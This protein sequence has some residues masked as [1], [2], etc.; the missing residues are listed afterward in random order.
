MGFWVADD[1]AD[2]HEHEAIEHLEDRLHDKFPAVPNARIDD[3]VEAHYHELD[4]QPVREYVPILV[5]HAAINEL[6][7]HAQTQ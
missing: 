6:W 5:E 7:P 2:Q 3:V 1:N 4:G